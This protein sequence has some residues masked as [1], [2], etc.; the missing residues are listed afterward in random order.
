VKREANYLKDQAIQLE[1]NIPI[2]MSKTPVHKS[3]MISPQAKSI[4]S[5]GEDHNIKMIQR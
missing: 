3:G 2:F 1:N 5:Y 4:T